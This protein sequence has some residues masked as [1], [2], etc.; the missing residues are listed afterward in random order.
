VPVGKVMRLVVDDFHERSEVA[1]FFRLRTGLASYLLSGDNNVVT[2]SCVLQYT[3][4]DPAKYLF[5]LADS[6]R[7]LRGLACN[8]L[9]HALAARSVD[10]ILT[11]GKGSI[12]RYVEVELQKRLDE[13]DSGLVIT[14]VELQEVRPPS[15]VQE[16]FNDVINA[17]IDSDKLVNNAISYRNEQV[18]RAKADAQRM[19]REAEA[20]RQR[21]AARAQGDA[22][23]FL[24]QLGEYRRAPWTTRRRLHFELLEDIL[25]ALRRSCVVGRGDDRPLARVVAPPAAE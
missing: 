17:K 25:P 20:H 1:D 15:R 8:T 23:R 14:F 18:P 13:L 3:I 12:Q 21:V 10:D 24:S 19:L 5:A 22:R 11:T 7:C 16:Y 2:V 6:E 4:H 9:I